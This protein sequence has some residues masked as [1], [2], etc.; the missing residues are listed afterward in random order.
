MDSHRDARRFRLAIDRGSKARRLYER[1]GFVHEYDDR[2]GV[3]RVFSAQ[4]N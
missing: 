1:L 4:G 2:N 3:D